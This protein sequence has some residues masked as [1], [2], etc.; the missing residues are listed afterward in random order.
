M[1]LSDSTN[2]LYIV[3]NQNLSEGAKI[4]QSIHAFRMFLEKHSEIERAW[5]ESSNCIV[6]LSIKDTKALEQLIFEARYYKIRLSVFREPD[7]PA[8]IT[9]IALEPSAKTKQILRHLST[10]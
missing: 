10:V 4:A 2:K 3:V 9:A 7:S 8:E 5:Y 1:L 6:V